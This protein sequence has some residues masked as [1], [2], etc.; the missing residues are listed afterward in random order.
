MVEKK[1]K[2]WWE[3]KTCWGG[4]LIAFGGT[5]TGLGMFLN[6]ALTFEQLVSKVIPLVGAGLSVV[7][8]RFKK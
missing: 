2:R 4:I 7:G 5:A 6:G 1:E 3:S 8:F